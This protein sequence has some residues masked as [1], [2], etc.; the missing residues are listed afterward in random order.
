MGDSDDEY[1]RKRRDKFRGERSAGGGG[2]SYG[3]GA[4]R[5]DRSRGRDDWPD[6]YSKLSHWLQNQLL[7][8]CLFFSVRPRQDYRDYRPPPRDRGYSPAREGPTVKRMRGD[9]W[10]DEGRHRFGGKIKISRIVRHIC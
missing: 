2:D 3:R 9:T 7:P 5:P 8:N 6:R 1:D 10:G 4:D